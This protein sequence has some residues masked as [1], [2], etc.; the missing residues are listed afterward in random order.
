MSPSK[1]VQIEEKFNKLNKDI[2]TLQKAIMDNNAYINKNQD[3]LGKVE[4][5]RSKLAKQKKTNEKLEMDLIELNKRKKQ[6]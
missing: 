4:Y 5:L 2:L 1:I 6:E 3:K